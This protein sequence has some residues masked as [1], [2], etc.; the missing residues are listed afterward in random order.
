MWKCID[1]NQEVK[2]LAE[3]RR[4]HTE[5]HNQA[6][7]FACVD[8]SKTYTRYRSFARHVKTHIDPKKFR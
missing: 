3:L 6:P 7:V 5:V 4:H 8:C 2:T 1:C